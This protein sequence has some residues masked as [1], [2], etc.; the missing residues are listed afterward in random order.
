M[1]QNFPADKAAQL[2][3]SLLAALDEKLQLGLLNHL[4]RCDSYDIDHDTLFITPAN[5]ADEE[6]LQREETVQHLLLIAEDSIGSK[7]IVIR[8][9][10]SSSTGN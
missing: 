4:K 10:K 9:A 8:S 2:W 5:E 1:N 3:Q 7:A 6:Y